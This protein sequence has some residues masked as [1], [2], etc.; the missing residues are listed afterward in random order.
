MHARNTHYTSFIAVY[1]VLL[2]RLVYR[3]FSLFDVLQKTSVLTRRTSR[4]V[5]EP[6][7]DTIQ[8]TW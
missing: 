5:A 8:E 7:Q 1:N 4:M 6:G 3:F 2:P